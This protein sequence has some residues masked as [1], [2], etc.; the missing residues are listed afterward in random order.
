MLIRD[1]LD[2]LYIAVPAVSSLFVGMALSRK[3]DALD[4][5]TAAFNRRLVELTRLLTTPV[6]RRPTYRP[7]R[8]FPFRTLRSVSLWIIFGVLASRIRMRCTP[9]PQPTPVVVNCVLAEMIE[10]LRCAGLVPQ[11]GD[12]TWKPSS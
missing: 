3:L 1:V 2:I 5:D 6:L 9:D 10:K 8:R 12:L 4:R 7:R 11:Q